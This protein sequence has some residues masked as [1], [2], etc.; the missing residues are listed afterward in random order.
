MTVRVIKDGT[1][2][3]KCQH[4]CVRCSSEIE[5]ELEDVKKGQFGQ[6]GDYNTEYYV[7]CLICQADMIVTKAVPYWVKTQVDRVDSQGGN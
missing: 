4:T 2:G 1:E 5:F 3:W 6:L 7:P